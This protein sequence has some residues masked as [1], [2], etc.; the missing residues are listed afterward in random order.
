MYSNKEVHLQTHTR[1]MHYSS[2]DWCF[3]LT[4]MMGSV[5]RHCSAQLQNQ[6]FKTRRVVQWSEYSPPTN[7]T[8]VRFPALASNV[9][10]VCWFSALHREIF[11]GYFG[12]PSLQKPKFD[13]LCLIVNFSYSVPNSCYYSWARRQNFFGLQQH[14][15]EAKGSIQWEMTH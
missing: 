1:D 8:R 10:W 3:L 4:K 6:I 15:N 13:L 11:S 12:F 7:V 5:S 2:L 14:A 9:G